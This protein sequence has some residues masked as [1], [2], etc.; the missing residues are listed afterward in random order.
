MEV[1]GMSVINQVL[2][3][4]EQRGAHTAVE[5]TMVRAVPI[6]RNTVRIKIA[7]LV[8]AAGLAVG[9]LAWKRLAAHDIAAI[10]SSESVTILEE[11]A[12]K[13]K[14]DTS[15]TASRLSFELNSVPLP[16]TLRPFAPSAGSG[17]AVRAGSGQDLHAKKNVID[18]QPDSGDVKTAGEVM[19]PV[20]NGLP[21]AHPVV[22]ADSV[23]VKLMRNFARR[24]R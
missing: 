24:Q 17:H 21:S 22:Q 20:R 2:N 8:L 11:S 19:L 15:L 16:S 13:P 12:V 4:L 10:N 7:L 23:P 3:Q 18:T 5:Q 6:A 1:A 14:T 9:A